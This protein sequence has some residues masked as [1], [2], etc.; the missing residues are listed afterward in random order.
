MAYTESVPARRPNI[1]ILNN[2]LRK[3]HM[4]LSLDIG[5]LLERETN[6]SRTEKKN[7]LRLPGHYHAFCLMSIRLWSGAIALFG[8][9]DTS[10]LQ[11]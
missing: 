5:I 7:C 8:S 3:I 2:D 4:N 11:I 1:A 10:L 9:L 6:R